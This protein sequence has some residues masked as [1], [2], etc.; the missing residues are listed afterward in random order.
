MR[1]C[2]AAK[3]HMSLST[4]EL[5]SDSSEILILDGAAI[6][7]AIRRISHE[8]LERNPDLSELAIIGI[9]TRGVELA[10]R[11]VDHIEQVEKTRPAFGM[12]DVSMHRD[13]FRQR[14]KISTV[15]ATDLPFDL[16]AYAVVLVDDVIFTGRSSRAAMD[17][18]S[19]FGRPKRIQYAALI[20][21]GH[22]ELPIHPDYVG[23]N[24]PTSR[25]EKVC[26]RLEGIDEEPDSVKVVK[27]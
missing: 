8:I 21:R 9:Q 26:V 19:S 14:P 2:E 23:K 16:N 13:D 5:E 27:P 24:V 15:K 20:D 25:A 18:L 3:E 12:V 1:S 4:S 10:R 11:I 17:A 6:Q 22:R 7:R